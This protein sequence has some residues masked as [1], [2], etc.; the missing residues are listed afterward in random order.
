MHRSLMR[1]LKHGCLAVALLSAA[2]ASADQP[3]TL[4][5]IKR[6]EAEQ[7]EAARKEKALRLEA[8]RHEALRY[9]AAG[10]LAWRTRQINDS[11]QKRSR[12]LSQVFDFA[13][14]TI[15]VSGGGLIVP[16]VV[17]EVRDPIAISSDG[18]SATLA[19]RL[20]RIRK[21]ARLATAAPSWQDYLRRE[22]QQPERPSELLHPQD[23][24]ERELW[25][26]W[27]EQGWK[28]GVAQADAI[29]EEDM[30]RL[31]ADFRGMALYRELVAR[32]VVS[33]L[34]L[35]EADLGVTGGGRELRVGDR[36]V[37]IIDPASLNPNADWRVIVVR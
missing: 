18:L 17:D 19:K 11:L 4:D 6:V 32:G 10:G 35:A 30:A 7:Q 24:E 37:R 26:G 34:Y 5:E 16:P 9:G 31:V 23:D 28:S 13:A 14:L 3:P 20:W 36:K 25:E 27:V 12:D 15:P 21:P 33:E 29:F 1:P 8:M 2:P 22:W